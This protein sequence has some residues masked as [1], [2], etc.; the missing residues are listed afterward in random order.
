[1]TNRLAQRR[2]DKAARRKKMLAERRKME[3]PRGL[4]SAAKAAARPIYCC[5]VQKGLFETGMGTVVLARTLPDGSLAM[6]SF[7]LDV[8]CLGVKDALYRQAFAHDIDEMKDT[9]GVSDPLLPADPSYARK[10]IREAVAYARS[11]GFEPH[12]DFAD[13]EPLF[14]DISADA[15]D[16]TF[17]FGRDGKPLYLAGP[18][19]APAVVE[20]RLA[21]LTERLGPDGFEFVDDEEL[22]DEL[23]GVH[24]DANEGPDEQEWAEL[25]EADRT[26]AVR[27]YHRRE[28]VELPNP[29]VHAAIHIIVE[30]Q[31]AL[32]DELPVRRTIARL[33][34]EGLS[35]H[36]AVHAVGSVL[37]E[38]IADLTRNGGEA[39]PAAYNAAVERLTAEGWRRKYADDSEE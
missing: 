3:V 31:A 9:F 23:V 24:Y 17:T 1:M 11:L 13:A 29:E 37:A 34:A 39:D 25:D 4:P 12:R 30:N 5:L 20:R 27:D 32:G 7:L 21:Q 38:Q 6:A 10:L 26:G 16:A 33:V 18:L 15:S 28:G 2:A 36:D 8:F 22:V 14:G 19:D 35:R